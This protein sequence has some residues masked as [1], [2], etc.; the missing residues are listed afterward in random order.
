MRTL[1]PTDLAYF[2]HAP[3]RVTASA[4]IAASPAEVFA[5]LADAAGWVRW[6]PLMHRAAWTRG[7]GG[8]DAERTVALRLFGQ[9]AERIIAWEPGARFAFT[10]IA[11]SSP[12]ARQMAEDYRLTAVGTGTRLDWVMAATPTAVGK[13]ASP[14]LTRIVGRLFAGAGRRLDRM[15]ANP[16][17]SSR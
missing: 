6:F 13:V 3:M 16:T 2:D 15:L 12:M 8:V 5:A 7:T 1:A 14:A 17:G 4:T 9:F 10:M 11:S